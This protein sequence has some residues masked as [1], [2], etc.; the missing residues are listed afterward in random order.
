MQRL[1]K[2]IRE[3][4]IYRWAGDLIGQ[5]CDV[6]LSETGPTPDRFEIGTSA[7]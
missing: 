6:R 3:K 4:N 1:R 5:L 7:A 2:L